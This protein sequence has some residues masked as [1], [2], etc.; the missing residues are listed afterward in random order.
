MRTFFI[1][2]FVIFFVVLIFYF[3]CRAKVDDKLLLPK[4]DTNEGVEKLFL[5][6]PTAIKCSVNKALIV[7][8][9]KL[10]EIISIAPADRTFSNTLGAIDTISFYLS[11]K[12]KPIYTLQ[13]VSPN[14]KI[15]DVAQ[16]SVLMVQQFSIEHIS[17]SMPLYNAVKEYVE[18]G[19]KREELNSQE[20]KY[21]NEI[22]RDFKKAGMELPLEKI[23]IIKEINKE[24]G[25]LAL[26][27]SI[28]INNDNSSIKV[29]S[30]GVLGLSEDFLK[31]VKKDK[32]GAYIIGTDYPT[33]FAVMENCKIEETRK[34][35]LMAFNNRAHPINEPIL[36]KFIALSDKK[37]K[38]IGYKS[39]AHLGIDGEMAKTPEKVESF[40]MGLLKKSE[41]KVKKEL[42]TLKNNLP[43]SVTLDENGKIKLWDLR[44][45]KSQYK[46]K[47]LTIDEEKIKEYFSLEKTLENIFK[48][49]SKFLSLRFKRE[50][51]NLWHESVR[52]FS[53]YDSNNLLLGYIL[54]DL[55]PRENK[56]KHAC[57]ITVTPAVKEKSG[58]YHPAVAT[59]L[60]N[61]PKPDAD[62]ISLLKRDDVITFFH[63]LGHA[64]HA[65][66]G[67][68][69]IAS[70]SGTSVETDFVEAPSQVLEE[71]MYEPEILKIVSAHYK[72]NE[73]IEDNIIEKIQQLKRFESGY[74][75][76][77]QVG[78]SL[79][80][81]QCFLE[82]EN[83]NPY[84]LKMDLFKNL[85]DEI[86]FYD[87]DHF[88]SSFGH[89]VSYKE[90]YYGYLWSK[91]FAID[92]FRHIKKS[93]LLNPEVG[94]LYINKVIGKGG[95]GDPSD[96]IKDF[97]GREPSLDAFFEELGL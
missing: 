30:E 76:K 21:L 77:R 58:E 95:S 17:N 87:W 74:F 55:F 63:E 9:K 80:S 68:T 2:L 31:R 56:F 37:A 8:K 24:L 16:K 48:I 90:G 86:A 10:D 41:P 85:F 94:Q 1:L 75:V 26:Q 7:S 29:N 12:I 72:T 6:S 88:E 67:A 43:E 27:F 4:I 52:S 34:R 40:L 79:F 91:V 83:K 92:I 42:K 84:Q 20:K 11:R 14:S 36:K 32:V 57:Q 13:M 3:C 96:Y 54:L 65:L 78:I 39:S 73:P 23:K 93:G 15:R 18:I 19:G 60:S 28:N 81:L 66:L 59:V 25:E 64:M 46:K 82:G 50:K 97:L 22:M 51:L 62:N 47:H 35:L 33:Y 44:Y 38:M 69:E 71:W 53:V 5:N 70:L 49:Y 89:I 61:F 45:I